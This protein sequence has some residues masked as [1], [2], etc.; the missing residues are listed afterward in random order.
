MD[1]IRMLKEQHAR[2]KAQLARFGQGLGPEEQPQRFAELAD[3][4]VI[5]CTIEE[6][7]FY[8]VARLTGPDEVVRE[9]VEEHLM[10]TRIVADLLRID[11][12]H[13]TW[14]AKLAVLMETL[15][16]HVQQVEDDLCPRVADAQ[17]EDQLEALG[18]EM[19]RSVARMAGEEPRLVLLEETGHA[20]TLH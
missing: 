8:P 9:V 4:M 16:H 15:D 13:E 17:G 6:E 2:L 14:G 11:P 5:H 12:G 7:H 1:A 10:L 20:E 18:R 3:E 19:G